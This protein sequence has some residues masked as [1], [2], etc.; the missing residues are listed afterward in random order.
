MLVPGPPAGWKLLSNSTVIRLRPDGWDHPI[1]EQFYDPVLL[2]YTHF[3]PSDV[4]GLPGALAACDDDPPL[5]EGMA[6][7]A[8]ARMRCL[9]Q[10]R[11][12][13]DYLLGVFD[14]MHTSVHG[15]AGGGW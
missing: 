7:A 13:E 14:Y 3:L 10:R 11:V 1:F 15:K 9:L 8:H 5:C 12:I 2:P 4:A 6:T